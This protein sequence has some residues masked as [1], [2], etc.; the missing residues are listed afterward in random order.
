[1]KWRRRRRR[2]PVDA[3]EMLINFIAAEWLRIDDAI[4]CT[5]C[6]SCEMTEN[7]KTG[8]PFV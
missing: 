3:D 1:M 7:H 6:K 5:F 2:H 8:R 4:T